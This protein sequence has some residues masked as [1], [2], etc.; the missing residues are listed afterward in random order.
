[1]STDLNLL[2]VK[3][4]RTDKIATA[5]DTLR[6]GFDLTEDELGELEDMGIDSVALMEEVK[7]EHITS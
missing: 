5:L 6:R 7:D 1:M 4:Y 2:L 3:M